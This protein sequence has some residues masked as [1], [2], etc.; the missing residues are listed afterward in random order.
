MVNSMINSEH[1]KIFMF[2]LSGKDLCLQLP[3]ST[4]YD[5]IMCSDTNEALFTEDADKLSILSQ[6]DIVFPG[7]V[8]QIIPH[9][10]SASSY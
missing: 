8:K 5:R 7:L 9:P 1:S 2:S 6:S 4:Q 10:Q 3:S